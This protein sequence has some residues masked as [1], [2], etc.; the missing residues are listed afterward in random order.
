MCILKS[1]IKNV[2]CYSVIVKSYLF[3]CYFEAVDIGSCIIE[4]LP[5]DALDFILVFSCLNGLVDDCL[6]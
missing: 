2:D 3:S 5:E 6:G 1:F 4:L